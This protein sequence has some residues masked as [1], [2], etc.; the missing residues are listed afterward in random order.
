MATNR[1]RRPAEERKKN[2][3][4]K[5]ET[6]SDAERTDSPAAKP[7]FRRPSSEVN[8]RESLSLQP[9]TEPHYPPGC[10][11]PAA[12]ME[13]SSTTDEKPVQ[14][15]KSFSVKTQTEVCASC[16]KV[17]YPMER[18]VVAEDQIFHSSCF[19]CKHCNTKLSLGSFAA[20]QGEFYC[21]PHFK[22]L[23]KSKGNYDEGFGRKQHKELWN[24]ETENTTKTA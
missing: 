24:K 22:Q 11:R 17:V 5:I 14:R 20:L 4:L 2:V 23:F 15:S 19:C 16:E 18:L 12:Q 13:T 3:L 1:V 6:R 8:E 9:P 21:K 7:T 10:L